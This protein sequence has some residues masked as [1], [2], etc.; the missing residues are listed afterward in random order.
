[1]DR[2][3]ID[4]SFIAVAPADAE[5]AAIIS[6]I[7]ALAHALDIEVVAEGVETEAQRDFLARCGCDYL[8]GYL[9]GRPAPDKDAA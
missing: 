4:R 1:V 8:Q 7:V 2:L 3:K 5:Q 6:A 9:L